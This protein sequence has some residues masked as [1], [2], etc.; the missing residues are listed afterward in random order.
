MG[1]ITKNNTDRVMVFIDV[2]NIVQSHIEFQEVCLLDFSE[3]VTS[4]VGERK[5]IRV[6]AYDSKRIVDGKDQNESFHGYLRSCGI[7][8]KADDT[9]DTSSEKQKEVDVQIACD[10]I[11]HAMRD[12]YDVA[13]LVSGDR[14]FVPAVQTV[15]EVG[16]NV[17]VASFSH[18]LSHYL[19]DASDDTY[20]LDSY[21]I[22]TNRY[23]SNEVV[24]VEL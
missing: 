19:R 12:N 14:D 1:L 3:I 9:I 16:K 15:K 11:R 4:I 5:L 18:S 7:D 8:V 6:Y 13:I 23:A 21:D 22:W 10:M 17:E 2:R 20:Y 24:D